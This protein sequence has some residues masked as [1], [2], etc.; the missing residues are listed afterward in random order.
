MERI[1]IRCM[2]RNSFF[3]FFCPI[4]LAFPTHKFLVTA[5]DQVKKCNLFPTKNVWKAKVH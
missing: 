4:L 1:F 2:G 5:L 3:S